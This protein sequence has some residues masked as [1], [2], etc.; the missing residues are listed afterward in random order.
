LV[1]RRKMNRPSIV[2]QKVSGEVR[3]L[4]V[5]R[6]Q[7]YRECEPLPLVQW[8]QGGARAPVEGGVCYVG[9]DPRGLWFYAY[10]EDS[11]ITTRARRDNEKMWELGDTVEFF[12]KP[13]EGRE[14]YWEVHV[15]PNDLIMDILIPSRERYFAGE[16]PWDDVVAA[17][18]G[19][20][21]RVWVSA[22][23]DRW[24]V[25]LCIPWAAVGYEAVPGAGTVWQV[26]VCRYN[27]SEGPGAGSLELSS[28]AH[29]T[30]LNF[31]RYEEHTD[32]VF[33]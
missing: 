31:H 5:E 24:A 8:W 14:D 7:K 3:D 6:P 33:D 22:A 18:S 32:L 20:A 29:L 27:Y 11:S 17:E 23:E 10:L 16:I 2:C 4:G 26:A 21:K 28:T 1:R 9:C 30:E 12:V 25:E 13:G 15:T 19:S